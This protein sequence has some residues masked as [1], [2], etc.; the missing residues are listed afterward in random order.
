MTSRQTSTNCPKRKK[1]T[2]G[3]KNIP[4]KNERKKTKSNRTFSRILLTFW[5]ISKYSVKLLLI[6][7]KEFSALLTKGL[8]KVRLKLNDLVW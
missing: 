6:H 7:K 4:M 1:E 3:M 2:Y 5:T 8:S